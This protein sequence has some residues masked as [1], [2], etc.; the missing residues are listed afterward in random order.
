MHQLG[1]EKRTKY[2]AK[3]SIADSTT[4]PIIIVGGGI[5]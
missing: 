2:M 3:L 5:Q 1:I 4:E